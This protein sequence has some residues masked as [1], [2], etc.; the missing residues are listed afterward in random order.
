MGRLWQTLILSRWQP[1]L[2]YLSV[3]TVIKQRQEHYYALLS[4][5]EKQSECSTFIEFLLS[6]IEAILTEAIA[7]EAKAT[8]QKTTLKTTQNQQA[9]LAFL[10]SHPQASRKDIAAAING[11]TESRL[12]YNLKKLQAAGLLERV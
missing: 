4:E 11:I 1:L 12:K 10:R 5:A 8:T 2:A 3:E 6:A 9:M 7:T